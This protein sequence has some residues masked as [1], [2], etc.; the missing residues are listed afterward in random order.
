MWRLKENVM[1]IRWILVGSSS[2]QTHLVITEVT[3][4]E[5]PIE[6]CMQLLQE[7][8]LDLSELLDK[9]NQWDFRLPKDPRLIQKKSKPSWKW[10]LANL[11]VKQHWN[12]TETT[13]KNASI[14]CLQMA[15]NLL[16]LRTQTTQM[17]ALIKIIVRFKIKWYKII[18]W[19]YHLIRIYL[20]SLFKEITQPLDHLGEL[21]I[22]INRELALDQEQVLVWMW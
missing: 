19:E 22:V 5:N 13:S 17:M 7:V 6:V 21:K 4:L 20:N 8:M 11:N 1:P 10:D 12:R 3:I 2:C 9:V 16:A 14:S 18:T 15:I